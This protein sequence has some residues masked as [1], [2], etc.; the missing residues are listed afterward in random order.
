M[1][2]ERGAPGVLPDLVALVALLRDPLGGF[3]PHRLDLGT[4]VYAVAAFATGLVLAPLEAAH[5]G[6][7]TVVCM[8]AVP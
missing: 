6:L 5:P 7:E 3:G 8:A 2:L 1:Y 4:D